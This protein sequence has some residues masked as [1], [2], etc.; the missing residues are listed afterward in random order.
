MSFLMMRFILLTFM[1]VIPK[2]KPLFNIAVSVAVRF[3]ICLALFTTI[4]ISLEVF[5]FE[6]WLL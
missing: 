3:L 4:L 2:F 1:F 5:I 6:V